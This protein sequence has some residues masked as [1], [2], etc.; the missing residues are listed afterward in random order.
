[1]AMTRR[2]MLLTGGAGILLAGAGLGSLLHS[3]LGKARAPW[4]A[5]GEG[6]DDARLNALSYAVLAPSPHNMQPWLARLDDGLGLTLFC[7]LERRLPNTDPLDRQ[8]VLGLGAFLEVL[9][10]A[11]A[12]A[13]YAVEIE[14]FPEGEPWPVMGGRPVASVRFRAGARVAKDPLFATVLDRRTS[15]VTFDQSALVTAQ[16]LNGLDRVLR[17][18]DGEFEWVNDKANIDALKELCRE[19]WKIEMATPQTHHESTALTRIGEKEI[20]ANPDGISLDGPM[21]EALL[22]TGIL[23]REEMNNTSSRAYKE[24][25]N[26]YAGLIDSAMA[27]GWLSTE[28]NSRTDQLRAGAGWVRLQ[29]AATAAGLSMQPLSQPLQEFPTMAAKFEEIHDFTGIRAPRSETDGRLQGLF[30]FGYATTPPPSPRWP[31]ESRL[32]NA[33]G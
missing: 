6:F 12:E 22:L 7:D 21:M 25:Y 2:V 27:F 3:D 29:Q 28:G 20:N 33:D 17:P 8:I 24:A 11:G 14:P 18:Q 10:Q 26:F 23:T 16:T 19:A 13:G 5:A 4:R 30:R 15:R 32:V 9:R 1:M 31:L